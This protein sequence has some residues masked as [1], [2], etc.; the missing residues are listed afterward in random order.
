MTSLERKRLIPG[1]T[2]M[3]GVI[4]DTFLALEAP[5]ASLDIGTSPQWMYQKHLCLPY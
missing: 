1:A 4:Q 5:Y 2:T 3:L